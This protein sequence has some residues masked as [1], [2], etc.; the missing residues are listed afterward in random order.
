MD[1]M[2]NGQVTDANVQLL[3]PNDAHLD[4]VNDVDRPVVSYRPGLSDQPA[5]CSGYPVDHGACF[6]SNNCSSISYSFLE[7]FD[8]N[9]KN[10]FHATIKK[11]QQTYL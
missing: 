8:E 5:T 4:S 3:Y 6:D 1:G 9:Y 7:D 11:Y 10:Y 2:F